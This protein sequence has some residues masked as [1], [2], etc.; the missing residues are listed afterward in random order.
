[1]SSGIRAGSRLGFGGPPPVGPGAPG[2][3]GAPGGPAWDAGPG[4]TIS[5]R[6]DPANPFGLLVNKPFRTVP[7]LPAPIV[8]D[9]A[10]GVESQRGRSSWLVLLIAPV[11]S[12]ATG[13]VVGALT[14]QWLFLLLGLG[15]VAGSLVPQLINRRTAA[16]H[17]PGETRVAGRRGHRASQAR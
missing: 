17:A 7:A 4:D 1:M 15:G 14:H 5:L 12:L 13:A 16:A 6:A 3:P 11:L 10:S 2:A 8:V 9:A